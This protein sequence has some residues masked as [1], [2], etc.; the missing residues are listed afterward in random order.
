MI[1]RMKLRALGFTC[2][3]SDY[4]CQSI[5]TVELQSLVRVMVLVPGDHHVVLGT[6]SGHLQLLDI[7]TGQLLDDI[8][9]HNING[10]NAADKKDVSALVVTADDKGLL[11]GGTNGIVRC[12]KFELVGDTE[13]GRKLSLEHTDIAVSMADA[14]TCIQ[15]SPDGRFVGVA[16]LDNKESLYYSDTMKLHQEIYGKSMPCRCMAFTHDGEVFV[17][18]SM[19][20]SLRIY[21]TNYGDLRKLLKNA[22]TGGVTCIQFQANTHLYFTAGH[23]GKINYWDADNFQRIMTLKSHTGIIRCLS[24]PPK[25]N[26]LVSAGQDYSIRLWERTDELLEL[27]EEREQERKKQEEEEEGEDGLMSGQVRHVEGETKNSEAVRASKP[28]YRT[29]EAVSRYEIN[30]FY[31]SFACVISV[32]FKYLPS[33]TPLSI[34][35]FCRLQ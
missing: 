30:V 9:A 32:K 35:G 22:H 3:R 10:I 19:D 7:N 15:C 12:W 2:V 33:L 20:S 13:G 11:S 24:L 14:I 26:W 21:G 31:T 27:E 16:T 29:D 34:A 4:E 5:K 8:S 18:G 6:A 17:T 28:T 1:S 25:G 23:D